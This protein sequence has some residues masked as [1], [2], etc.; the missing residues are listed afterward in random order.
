MHVMD[1]GGI[2]HTRH[3]R[4]SNYNLISVFPDRLS[5]RAII[6]SGA[7]RQWLSRGSPVGDAG[8]CLAA[9]WLLPCQHLPSCNV[10]R[11]LDITMK[12]GPV[13]LALVTKTQPLGWLVCCWSAPP[14]LWWPQAIKA[15][16]PM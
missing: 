10:S 2:P 9:V 14:A 15:V 7:P 8:H 1:K 6:I 3:V 5:G 4:G 11:L 16:T 12:E 13:T